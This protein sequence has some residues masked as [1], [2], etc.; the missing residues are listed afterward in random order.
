MD[1]GPQ[2]Y[3]WGAEHTVTLGT[4]LSL[5]SSH[6]YSVGA[7]ANLE[8]GGKLDTLSLF[9]RVTSFTSP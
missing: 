1:L 2:L 4:L 5:R 8:K 7:S 6:K 3:R 9:V